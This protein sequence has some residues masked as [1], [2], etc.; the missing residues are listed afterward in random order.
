MK[1]I[2]ALLAALA[3]VLAAAAAPAEEENAAGDALLV[4]V[5]GKEIRENSPEV[6][7]WMEDIRN[8]YGL[9]EAAAEEYKDLLQRIAIEQVLQYAVADTVLAQKG[10]GVTDE[11]VR[12]ELQNLW[13][14]TV[15]SAVTGLTET[16]TEEEK[17]AARKAA[18]ETVEANTGYTA[19]SLLEDAD[20]LYA[21]RINLMTAAL[22]KYLSAEDLAVTDEDVEA[23]HQAMAEQDREQ[24]EKYAAMYGMDPVEMYNFY[25]YVAGRA[26]Y[27][28]PEGFRGISHILL[29][30]DEELMNAYNDL[31][32]R[33]EA[34]AAADGQGEDAEATPEA[35]AAADAE[36]APDAEAQ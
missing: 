26:S 7:F 28:I 30:V 4:T 21:T 24:I 19:E 5:N 13:N 31:V 33:L 16:S 25:S 11:A 10:D 17:E 8:Y 15:E 2:I 27:Y 29:E 20:M 32:A 9:D 23:Y 6:H 35:E 34:Q 36:A 12:A 22:D 1:K 3:M 14:T 18:Q